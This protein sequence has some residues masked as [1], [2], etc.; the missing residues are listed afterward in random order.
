MS[1]VD[2]NE[3]EVRPFEQAMDFEK[4]EQIAEVKLLNHV[5][6]ILWDL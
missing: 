2:S 6:H 5:T 4:K 3:N 1:C